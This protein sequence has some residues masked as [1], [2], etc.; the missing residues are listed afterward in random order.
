[1]VRPAEFRDTDRC[2]LIRIITDCICLKWCFVA[3]CG[4]IRFYALCS[5]DSLGLIDT[6]CESEDWLECLDVQTG[7][8]LSWLHMSQGKLCRDMAHMFSYFEFNLFLGTKN[9]HILLILSLPVWQNR[10]SYSCH[11]DV[12]VLV[13]ITLTLKFYAQAFKHAY[14]SN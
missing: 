8:S 1:M 3:I 14:L 13:S 11:L 2:R 7:L 5:M 12:S 9:S 6:S 10:E 4:L